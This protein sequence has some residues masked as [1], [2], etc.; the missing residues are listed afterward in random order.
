M[1]FAISA[2]V[3]AV[4]LSGCVIDAGEHGF[5]D[6]DVEDRTRMAIDACGAGNV[7]EVTSNGF[8][9]KSAD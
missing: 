7:A 4:L 6:T 8:R 1:K 3:A 9:C 2:A 5:S